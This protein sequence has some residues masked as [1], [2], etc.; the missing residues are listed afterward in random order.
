MSEKENSGLEALQATSPDTAV[1]LLERLFEVASPAGVFSEPVENGDYMVITA[2]EVSVG[3]GAGFGSGYGEEDGESGVGGGGGGG[4]YST[5]RPIAAI[6]IGPAGVRVEPIVDPTKIA[7]AFFST[8]AAIFVA[9]SRV[10]RKA[11]E[12]GRE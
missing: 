11:A 12:L 1:K 6:E 8:F 7:I 2:S 4:G 5:G 9:I 3:M 10:R